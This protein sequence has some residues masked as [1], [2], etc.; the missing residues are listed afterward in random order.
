MHILVDIQGAQNGSRHRGIGRYSRAFVHSLSE[1]CL[2]RHRISLLA[3]GA[4]ENVD[5]LKKMFAGYIHE[6]DIH[7]WYPFGD[8]SFRWLGNDLRRKASEYLREAVIN[9]IDPD[10][11]LVT[12]AIEG[13]DDATVV[14]INKHFAD[15][16][17]AVIFYDAIPKIYENEYLIDPRAREWYFEKI[18]QIVAADVLLSISQSSK[19]EAEKY[20]GVASRNVINISTALS[21]EI[22]SQSSSP[23]LEEVSG[24]FD[25]G[26]D[27][28]LYSGAS[29]PRKN[30]PRLVEAYAGLPANIRSKSKL[31][32]AGGMPQAH[33]SHLLAL[34]DSLGVN[35]RVICTGWVNDGELAAI[36][37]GA[38]LFVFPSFHEGFGLP[39]LEAMRFDVPVIASNVSSIPEVVALDE[40]LF[41]PFET[42]SLRNKLMAALSDDEFRRRLLANS[43][44][45]RDAFSWEMTARRALT[46]LEHAPKRSRKRADRQNVSRHV[47]HIL[48][49][50]SSDADLMHPDDIVGPIERS[51]PTCTR[52]RRIF[53][54]VSELHARDSR[55]GIQRVVRNVLANLP[56]AAG[57]VYQIVPVATDLTAEYQISNKV[58]S[59]HIEGFEPF[60]DPRIDFSEGDIF[61]GLD[62][63]DVL[64]P[65]RKSFFDNIR[66][67][68]VLC[69]FV[70]YDLLP[71]MLPKAFPPE[72]SRNFNGWINNVARCDG[73]IAISRAV[74][75][76]TMRWIDETRLP[77]TKPVKIGHFRLGADIQSD[78]DLPA[79]PEFLSWLEQQ[80][81]SRLFLSVGTLEPRKR[82]AQVLGAIDELWKRAEPVSLVIVGKQ[83]WDCEAFVKALNEHPENGKRL[84]W[85]D[86]A[87][88]SDLL[89]AMDAADALIAA[90][91]NEGFGLPLVEAQRVGLPIIVRDIPVF[92]EVSGENAT[93]FSGLS[94]ARLADC[95][96]DWIKRTKPRQR[97]TDSLDSFSWS[98]SDSAQELVRVI[99]QNNWYATAI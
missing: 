21:S 3:N 56:Q 19:L 80:Q 20:F 70:V 2:G 42:A 40:A 75:N 92:R 17:T 32:L 38:R 30:L 37:K 74:A 8:P 36:Y 86:D 28:I 50:L 18:D 1:I 90:S 97:S 98:W 57:P 48:N 88:D 52:Q 14:T 53:V 60:I 45:R 96:Q 22:D 31:V 24:R 41:D 25:L 87:S 71:L 23:S 83:G 65:L 29:D 13:C 46:V 9:E 51:L 93:F 99:C 68:G 55:T 89:A 72:V 16:F 69:Y 77:L 27:Y 43:R 91:E 5:E 26:T 10:A 39:I 94:D 82:H 6:D 34:A 61:L 63:Q 15:T 81:Q 35:D 64:I 59:Q 58:G 78:S 85:L 4:F 67:K 79:R 49:F 66:D 47:N 7:V 73:L 33:I 44:K 62:F 12:S 76:D 11:L 95:L 84:L 54:D